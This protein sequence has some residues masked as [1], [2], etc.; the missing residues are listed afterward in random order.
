MKRTFNSI[1]FVYMFSNLLSGCSQDS[2]SLIVFGGLTMGTSYTI[3]IVED[4]KKLGE[5]ESD[6]SGE[7]S[8][9]NNVFSNYIENSEI[10]IFNQSEGKI[11]VSENLRELLLLSEE[12]YRLT[13]GGFDIHVGSL[14][15]RWGFGPEKKG[16]GVPSASEIKKM[17]RHSDSKR[18]EIFEGY[19]LKPDQLSLDVS[20]VA[21]GYGVDLVS[22]LLEDKGFENFLVEIGGE[23]K[24]VGHNAKGRPWTIGIERP[25][26]GNR[27]V[28][29]T[30][31]LMN[32]AMATSGDYRNF[33][34]EGGRVYSHT[35]NP[36]TGHPVNHDLA[37]VTVLHRDAAY[38]DALATGLTAIGL[39]SMLD[40]S[41]EKNLK[42][43][44]II[45]K[46]KTFE[47]VSSNEFRK[48]LMGFE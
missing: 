1:F 34:K 24:V 13:N 15:N 14:V 17:L 6:V 32:M 22:R 48:Y 26:S 3:K 28:F 4:Q 25:E 7:L 46:G 31:P 47:V 16:E 36:F 12:V 41:E 45:R 5:I 18:I 44:A 9:L 39:D 10:S 40:I 30:V 27:S 37:S 23:V 21:K 38:A 19:V 29:R 20:G 43:M 2:K 35:I 42:A 8:R 11:T 33:Y